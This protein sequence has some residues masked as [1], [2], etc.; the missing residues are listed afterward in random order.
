MYCIF[1]II[2]PGRLTKILDDDDDDE[3]QIVTALC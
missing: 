3:Q 2:F 1:G